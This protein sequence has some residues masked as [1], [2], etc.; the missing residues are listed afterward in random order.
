MRLPSLDRVVVTASHAARRF[1]L[2]LTCA[3]IAAISAMWLVEYEDG[4]DLLERLL[5]ASTLGLPLFVGL[6]LLAERQDWSGGRKVLVHLVGVLLLT[7]VFFLQPTWSDPVAVLRYAQLSIAFHLFAAFAPYLRAGE[8]NGFWQYNRSLLLHGLTAAVFAAVL[9]V[10]MAGALA[11]VDNLLGIEVADLTYARLWFFFAFVFSTWFF[12]G[13]MPADLEK[14]EKNRGYPAIIKVFSQFIL[15][16]I[17]TVYLLILTVY[18]GKII[19][20]RVWP[21]GWIGY[22]VSGVAALGILSLLLVHP[23]EDRKENHWIRTYGRWF[24]VALIPSIVMLLLAIWKRIDQY[25]IT[26]NRYFL[27]VLSLW[28]AGIALFF[29]FKRSRNIKVIP[30]TLCLVALVTIGGPWGAYAVSRRSQTARLERLLAAN[31]MLVDGRVRPAPA[32]LPF[33]DRKELSAIVR[34]LAETH[35]TTT[36]D[37][38]FDGRLAQIDTLA[39]DLGP[40]DRG[41]ADLR[42]DLIL[43]SL[44]VEYVG[45]WAAGSNNTFRFFVESGGKFIPV[46]GYEFGIR[47]LVA[48]EDTVAIDGRPYVFELDEERSTI[49]M[50]RVGE[51]LIEIPL[52]S[53]IQRAWEYRISHAGARHIPQDIFQITLANERVNL[54]VYPTTVRG[55]VVNPAEDEQAVAGRF[56]IT[57]FTADYFWSETAEV[58]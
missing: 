45:G 31:D 13:G 51:V 19:V 3:L 32:V 50:R 16:P 33:E 43:G 1:P 54:A 17:V 9:W 38:W 27:V 57:S 5:Y 10:G 40:S 49:V 47:G 20:T 48:N 39:Q 26:E 12:L 37:P 8:L 7:T 42:A 58:P 46:A 24:Y 35:G 14:L 53:I 29:I 11:G 55:T 22:L 4:H 52:D 41:E 18:L 21:S 23:I 30:M 56:R 34:Y 36:I 25:G 28:L 6:S 2:V 44:A 15:T